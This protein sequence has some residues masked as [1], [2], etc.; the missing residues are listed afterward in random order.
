[1]VDRLERSQSTY[2]ILAMLSEGLRSGY[3]IKKMLSQG[4]MFYWKESYGNIYPILRKLTEDSL[5]R[6]IA[7]DH[8]KK[9]RIYYEL[10]ET[11]WE[12][13]LE[14][15]RKPPEL[16]R[17]RVELLMKLRFGE[18]AG[19]DT[20]KSHIEHYRKVNQEE[21]EECDAILEEMKVLGSGLTDE[22]RTLTVTYL[23]RFKQAILG[24]CDESLEVL[25]FLEQKEKSG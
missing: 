17:F 8:K 2:G 21:I 3:E 14:W 22:V 23:T 5:V 1:V 16:G 13:L 19:I 25:D 15:L 12:E 10:T 9:K 4:E 6:Q 20:M 24:W 11:G 7:A 18:R